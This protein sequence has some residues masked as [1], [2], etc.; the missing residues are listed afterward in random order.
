MNSEDKRE[1]RI[2]RV[3]NLIQKRPGITGTELNKAT[4]SISWADMQ[5]ILEHLIDGEGSVCVKTERT[6]GRPR[7]TYWPTGARQTFREADRRAERAD[8]SMVAPE[9]SP[10][11]QE[12]WR[13]F[14]AMT[15]RVGQ[16]PI[17]TDQQPL[18]GYQT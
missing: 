8:G 1:A 5:E 16:Q 3:H 17:A 10:A 18:E 11:L 15:A 6:T 12:L 7:K 2:D 14:R 4:G 9:R 13:K